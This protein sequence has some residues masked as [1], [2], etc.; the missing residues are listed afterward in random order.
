MMTNNRYWVV[1]GEFQSTAFDRLV[2]GTERVFGPFTSRDEAEQ[3]WRHTSERHRPRCNV[4]FT[5]LHEPTS[6]AS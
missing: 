2:D 1:G 4:R 5:I 3:V 6:V